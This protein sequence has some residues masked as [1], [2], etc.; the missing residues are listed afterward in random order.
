[1]VIVNINQ[2]TDIIKFICWSLS[3]NTC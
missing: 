3:I 2:L 1:V